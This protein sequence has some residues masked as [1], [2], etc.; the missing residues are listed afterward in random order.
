MSVVQPP[1][2]PVGIPCCDCPLRRRKLFRPFSAVGLEFV[3][4]FRVGELRVA[5]GTD[6]L[7]A[8]TNNPH[9]YTVLAGAD[10]FGVGA[11]RPLL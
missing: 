8:G 5:A 9:L 11:P 2:R 6:I 4:S 1:T 3:A 7:L 10:A